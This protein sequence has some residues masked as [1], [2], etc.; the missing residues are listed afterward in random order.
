MTPY[1][2]FHTLVAAI[3][4]ALYAAGHSCGAQALGVEGA[5]LL[6]H[7]QNSW[8]AALV[9]QSL[10][11]RTSVTCPH[12]CA[13]ATIEQGELLLQ[14]IP[15]E[16]RPWVWTELSGAKK[17]RSEHMASYYEAMVDMGE[18]SSEFTHQIELVCPLPLHLR[19]GLAFWLA[20]RTQCLDLYLLE[21]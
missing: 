20:R 5:E 12:L 7:G 16:H 15:P 4:T 6:Q 1:S 18:S 8:T 21:A 17:R 2:S 9:Q 3:K 11:E 14:G 10:K 13:T 19:G